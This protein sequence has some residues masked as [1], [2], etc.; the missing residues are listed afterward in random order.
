MIKMERENKIGRKAVGFGIPVLIATILI[1][2]SVITIAT[3]ERTIATDERGPAVYIVD[4][5]AVYCNGGNA[6]GATVL[7]TPSSGSSVTTT[8]GPAGGW[9]TGYW[10]INVGSVGGPGWE[11]GT[12]FS[13]LI[14]ISGWSGTQSGFTIVDDGSY[15]TDTGTTTLNP[16]TSV[17]ATASADPTTIVEGESVDFTGSATG[18]TGVYTWYWDF[19]GDGTS[20]EQNPSH[21][22]N[23]EGTYVCTLTA[24]DECSNSDDDTVTITVNPTLSCDAH[25]PYTGTTCSCVQFTGSASGGHPPYTYDWDFGDGSS[26]SSQQNPCHLYGNDGSYTATLTVTDSNSDTD[27]DTAPVTIYTPPV[28]ADAHGPYTGTTCSCVQF[29]GSASG[30]CSPYSYDWDFGDGDTSTQ[31][32]PC[33]L[34]DNNGS[35]T[36][37]LTVTDSNSDTDDDTAPVTISTPPPVNADAHGPYRGAPGVPIQ[38]T[39]SASG[40]CSPYDYY[41]EFGDG[42][43][44]DEQNPEHQ[45]ENLGNYTVTLTVTDDVGDSDDD[46]TWAN[47]TDDVIPDLEC[48]G[49]LSWTDVTPGSTVTGSFK[50]KNVGDAGSKLDWEIDDYPNWGIWTFTPSSGDDL[51][52]DDPVTVG[53]TVIAP[54]EPE[55]TFT[56]EVKIVNSE[57]PDDT[58]IIN[59]SL[60]TPVNQQVV[61]NPLLQMIL[62]RFPNAFPILRHLMGL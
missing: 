14:T 25:G 53:V 36:A 60:A 13:V 43:T 30:G 9:P 62:E 46:V 34:Y 17:V 19:D 20:T 16:T 29:T 26:H 22:F 15:H 7:L 27:D 41:W 58:C 35:Y 31:Q 10:Q 28:N 49:S 59:V 52:P 56:G 38:F 11:Y 42:D 47:I 57:D 23:D 37:T 54:D 24:T 8:V 45:Y 18:G 5:N 6:D 48:E 21:T 1:F 40:G 51:L 3:D 33:H 12:T 44:S 32:N 50:V 55:E 2:S 61:I 4:G 39:G